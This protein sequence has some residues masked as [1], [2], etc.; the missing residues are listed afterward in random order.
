MKF[1]WGPPVATPPA[2]SSADGDNTGPTTVGSDDVGEPSAVGSGTTEQPD[3][4]NN[5]A[6]DDAQSAPNQVPPPEIPSEQPETTQQINAVLRS[7]ATWLGRALA[8]LGVMYEFDP[9]V[10]AVLAAI[11]AAVWLAEYS[12]KI[13]SYLDDPKTLAE[14]QRAATRPAPPGMKFTISS[15]HRGAQIIHRATLETSRI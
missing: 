2:P 10:A 8:V 15:R 5:T 3:Q 11:E 7:L 1:E 9:E 14:L 13:F 4:S 6:S 12:P